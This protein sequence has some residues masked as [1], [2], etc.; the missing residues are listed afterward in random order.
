[1][2]IEFDIGV[3]SPDS[4]VDQVLKCIGIQENLISPPAICTEHPSPQNNKHAQTSGMACAIN[5]IETPAVLGDPL[6]AITL[7]RESFDEHAL[8]CGFTDYWN[9]VAPR[10]NELVVAYIAEAFQALGID[11][12]QLEEGQVLPKVNHLPKY[13]KLMARLLEILE[14]HHIISQGTDP[15]RTSIRLST[16][17]STDI[18]NSFL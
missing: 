11:L 12:W 10:Q 5:D 3:I 18:L 2:S 16:K 8:S 1:M 17:S 15:V 9:T 4:T 7:C 6:Q 14:K 13:S